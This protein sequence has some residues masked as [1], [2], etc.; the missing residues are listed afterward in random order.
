M[1]SYIDLDQEKGYSKLIERLVE[2][3]SQP[4]K[5]LEKDK[6]NEKLKIEVLNDLSKE[7][8]ALKNYADQLFGINSSFKKKKFNSLDSLILDGSV[9]ENAPEGEFKIQIDDLA[10]K[11]RIAS[12]PIAT[13]D[14][15]PAGTFSLK[16]GDKTNIFRF[17]G[18]SV[19]D[20]EKFIN[21]SSQKTIDFTLV[22]RSK[23]ETLAIMSSQKTGA[24]QEIKLISDPEKILIDLGF[25]EKNK[26]QDKKLIPDDF[27]SKGKNIWDENLLKVSPLSSETIVLPQIEFN[28]GDAIRFVISWR[29]LKKTQKE[30]LSSDQT[31]NEKM[32]IEQRDK[33]VFENLIF[34]SE[35]IIPFTSLRDSIKEKNKSKSINQVDALFLIVSG[36]ADKPIKKKYHLP[37]NFFNQIYEEKNTII[38]AESFFEK[39]TG[40]LTSL[41]FTNNNTSF[42]FDISNPLLVKKNT[43]KE[44]VPVNEITAPENAKIIYQGVQIEREDNQIT[45]LIDG[46]EFDLKSTSKGDVTFNIS[47]DNEFVFNSLINFIGQFNICMGEMNT[48][49]AR[50]QA[51]EEAEEIEKRKHGLFKNDLTLKL[52]R[53][54]LRSITVKS[55]PTSSPNELTL[56]SQLGVTSVFILGG[57]DDPDSKK[58]DFQEET[59]RNIYNSSSDLVAELFGYDNDGDL[60]LDNGVAFEVSQLVRNYTGPG[61]IFE[62]KKRTSE[63][64]I[65]NIDKRV[66]KKEEEVKSYRAKQ[67][68]DFAKLD[69]AERQMEKMQDLLK[70]SL[71][72]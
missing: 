36:F 64:K 46:V 18:G 55:H 9:T 23:N 52:M 50:N 26:T 24:G 56:L 60:I 17:K 61:S 66:Q 53:D 34:N 48:L 19:L 32:K 65:K 62:S 39:K 43:G 72:R 20:L 3:K 27:D 28:K 69:A 58:L 33:I 45:D 51:A 22:R 70:N 8:T 12:R 37:K 25:Y 14:F 11:H 13:D 68:E 6:S 63:Q 54:K 16:V 29:D 31:F 71:D 35:K 10:K 47:K 7:L 1:T 49:L 15:I 5:Q 40:L 42:A 41:T 21:K 4:I 67:E 57:V 30:T 2:A 38:S 59:Y 44:F